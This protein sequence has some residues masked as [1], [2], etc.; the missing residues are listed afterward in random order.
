LE[1]DSGSHDSEPLT[2]VTKA[3]PTEHLS[4]SNQDGKIN[5]ESEGS[6]FNQF[7]SQP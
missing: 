3:T 1:I 7:T 5:S 6:M 2:A 4:E